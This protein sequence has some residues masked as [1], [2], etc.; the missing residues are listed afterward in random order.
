MPTEVIST[1][2]SYYAI[3]EEAGTKLHLKYVPICDSSKS[4]VHHAVIDSDPEKLKKILEESTANVNAQ[5]WVG[6][7][8]MH[9]AVVSGKH[10]SER[11]MADEGRIECLRLLLANGANPDIQGQY[12]QYPM[13]LAALAP[14]T[15]IIKM[16][17][18]AKASILVT[19]QWGQTPV[20]TAAK[21]K[22]E[23][24]EFL[25]AH[26]D[27]KD[28]LEVMD[29]EGMTPLERAKEHQKKTAWP[30]QADFCVRTLTELTEGKPVTT[31]FYTPGET[32]PADEKKKKKATK[33]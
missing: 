12:G 7:T 8:P 6:D 26:P 24:L 5:D 20:H 22:N 11:G 10:G 28:A 30:V 25:A 31:I 17:V 4:D 1:G 3:R 32:P 19:D 15:Q 14:A 9:I 27:I 33:K 16:M 21:G 2:D 23:Q 29:N 13:H 18:E